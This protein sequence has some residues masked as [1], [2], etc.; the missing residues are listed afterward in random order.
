MSFLD[1]FDD[2]L[3]R[4][5]ASTVGGG[6]LCIAFMLAAAFYGVI[7]LT[8]TRAPGPEAPKPPPEDSTPESSW[9]LQT[10]QTVWFIANIVLVVSGLPHL[11]SAGS[12]AILAL[13]RGPLLDGLPRNPVA[14]AVGS[15]LRVLFTSAL[16]TFEAILVLSVFLDTN[17]AFASA[18]QMRAPGERPFIFGC[19]NWYFSVTLLQP[20]GAWNAR[21]V[22]GI[23]AAAVGWAAA[24]ALPGECWL[25]PA[26]WVFGMAVVAGLVGAVALKDGGR[27]ARAPETTF[28]WEALLYAALVVASWRVPVGTICSLRLP[29][30]GDRYE[31]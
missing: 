16:G 21:A 20:V 8:T 11:L 4:L 19:A 14:S 29:G 3:T 28:R 23:M 22:F 24:A 6:G 1:R 13:C 30:E 7:E 17:A 15:V 2:A 12:S 5:D 27:L 26:C 10:F 9:Y 25:A 18:R 31:V